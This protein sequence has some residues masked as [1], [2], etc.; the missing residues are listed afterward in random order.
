[1]S[2]CSGCGRQGRDTTDDDLAFLTTAA[3]ELAIAIDHARL[4]QA[5]D[6]ALH[7][8][9][10][11]L[12]T[13]PGIGAVLAQRILDYRT[14]HGQFQSVNELRQVDGIGDATFEKLKDKVTV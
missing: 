3:G 12:Q 4:Y 13:L 6:V 1:M 9:V 5:T 7:R 14:A 10:A 2:C 8:K 11:E